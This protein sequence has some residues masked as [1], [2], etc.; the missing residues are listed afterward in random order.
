MRRLLLSAFAMLSIAGTASA[1]PIVLP[2]DT[3]LFFQ[4]VNLEQVDTNGG[5]DINVP[6]SLTTVYGNAGNWGIFVITNI[7]SGFPVGAPNTDI[8]GGGVN[9][10]FNGTQGS[11]YGIF[12]DINLTGATTA[13]G[14]HL[15]LY[16]SDATGKSLVGALPNSPTVTSFTSGTF[17]ARL[18]FASGILG[19]ADCTTTISSNLDPTTVGGS[20]QAD[21]FANVNTGVSGAWTT[22]LNGNWFN[23]P[24]GIRDIR[25]SNFF[26]AD[27][28]SWNG[29]NALGLRSNDPGRVFT[30]VP[31]PATMALLGLGLLGFARARRRTQ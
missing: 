17:L 12:Y 27:A 4:F 10:V 31:E 24:C 23:T 8:Q 7:Q 6:D 28:T 29:T 9:D 20:G 5:N 16:W 25:F 2:S 11:I 14:G 22:S 15:D 13:T 3:P 19:P 18:D 30:A 21:S 26:N 1:A